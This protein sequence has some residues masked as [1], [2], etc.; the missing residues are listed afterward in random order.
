MA[1]QFRGNIN[2]S[3]RLRWAAAATLG[4]ACL[5]GC[6]SSGSAAPET[7]SAS[8]GSQAIDGFGPETDG[9]VKIVNGPTVP[10]TF[11]S[12]GSDL[13]RGGSSVIYTYTSPGHQTP[14]QQPGQPT[15]SPEYVPKAGTFMSGQSTDADC[16]T[17]GRT[18]SSVPSE[19]ERPVTSDQWFRI[20][21]GTAQQYATAVY[22]RDPQ[23]ALAALPEC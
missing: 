11:D 6:G 19:G 22:I 8:N 5:A 15:P 13:S 3:P 7:G 2:I 20:D 12:L 10:I 1:E 17:T 16:K 4:I 18:I 23:A 9:G 21:V 14:P